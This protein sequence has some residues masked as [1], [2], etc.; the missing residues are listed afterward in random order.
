M[1]RR[2]PAGTHRSGAYPGAVKLLLDTDIGNDIDDAVCLAYLLARPDCELLGVTT[3]TAGASSRASL[4]SALCRVA[5]ARVPV[6]PGA[7]RPLS[8]EPLQ[9]PPPQAEALARWPHDTRFPAGEAVGFLRDTIRRYPGEVTLVTIGP[10]TNVALL[11]RTDPAIAGLLGGLVSM[12]G[13]YGEDSAEWNVRC[14]PEAAAEVYAAG[15][16]GHRCLGLD[17]TRQVWLPADAFRARCTAPL[18]RAVLDF[19]GTWFATRDRVTFH[20]PLAAATVFR[21]E[22]CGYVGGTVRVE[23]DGYTRFVAG[24]GPHRVASTVDATRFLDHYFAV[25][26]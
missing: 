6:F 9:E 3:V 21:P 11:L 15:V 14:D 13:A 17:V 23:G 25:F 1:T 10:L 16:P 18:L 5:G 19:A 20:D 7:E 24:P 26:E 22:L 2:R 12:A 4:A 8:R